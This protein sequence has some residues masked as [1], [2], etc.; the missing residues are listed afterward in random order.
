MVPLTCS[1]LCQCQPCELYTLVDEQFV[2]AVFVWWVCC[3]KA[4]FEMYNN[5]R[6]MCST[7]STVT[8]KISQ[9]LRV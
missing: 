4:T 5:G 1:R 8:P 7:Y 9:M 3:Y 6:C 2:Y